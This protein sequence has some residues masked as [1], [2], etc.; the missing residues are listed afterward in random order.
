MMLLVLHVVYGVFWAGRS[1]NILFRVLLACYMIFPVV[2]VLLFSSLIPLSASMGGL[3][4]GQ[5][6][7]SCCASYPYNVLDD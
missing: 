3:V 5:F 1:R 6:F 2:Q 7:C 4:R